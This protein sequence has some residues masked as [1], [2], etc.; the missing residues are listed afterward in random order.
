M[1]V[2]ASVSRHARVFHVAPRP[3]SADSFVDVCVRVCAASEEQG[4]AHC[5]CLGWR[6]WRGG[7]FVNKCV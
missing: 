7:L 5:G 3:F 2:A 6:R 1:T 4:G